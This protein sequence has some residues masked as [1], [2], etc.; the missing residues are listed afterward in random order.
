MIEVGTAVCVKTDDGEKYGRVVGF[1][2]NPL[3]YPIVQIEFRD[4]NTGD[5][6]VE[7]FAKRDVT[8]A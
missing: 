2:K 7:D 8:E 5:K 4:S 3:G 6:Y 1:S